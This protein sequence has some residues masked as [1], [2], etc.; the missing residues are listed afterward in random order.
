VPL[1]VVID[2]K[3]GPGLRNWQFK[4]SGIPFLNIRVMGDGDLDFTHIKF[5]DEVE[6]QIKYKHFLLQEFDHVISTSGTLGKVVTIRDKHLPICLNTSI[7][8]MRPINERMGKW[9]IK[10]Y[11][12]SD[13]FL[14]DMKSRATGSAQLNFGPKHLAMM[15]VIAPAKQIS[16]Q[17]EKAIDPIEKQIL[18]LFDYNQTLKEA[19]DLLLPRLMNQTIEV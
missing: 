3:E 13:I 6:V 7:I 16:I 18:N 4:D 5:L 17:F 9:H 14:N 12:K 8:R 11:M 2:Y 19:R 15:S 10:E 1:A